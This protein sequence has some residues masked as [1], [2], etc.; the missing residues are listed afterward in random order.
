MKK[1]KKAET[2]TI[3]RIVS[4]PGDT[5]KY[6]Y[7]YL[8]DG[9]KFHFIS[10]G[11]YFN[12]PQILDYFAIKDINADIREIKKI[13]DKVKKIAIQFNCNICTVLECIRTVQEVM[14]AEYENAA[15]P[16]QGD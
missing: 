10:I 9:Y 1:I 6:D 15:I 7:G 16:K 13:P 4:E 12:Y 8:K 3:T 14:K 5:T 11:N 2:I